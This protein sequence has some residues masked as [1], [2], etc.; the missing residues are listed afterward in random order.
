[1][2]KFPIVKTVTSA[3]LLL[4][5]ALSAAV[6]TVSKDGAADF[7]SIQAAVNRAA[8]DDEIII[9]GAAVYEEQVIIDSTKNGLFLHSE[10]V[11]ALEKPTIKWSDTVNIGPKTAAEARDE[12]KI[13]F[14][15]NGAL[16]ILGAKRVRIEGIAVDGGSV[17]PMGYNEVWEDGKGQAWPLQF[18]NGGISLWMAGD[19]IIRYCNISNAFYGINVKDRNFGGVFANSNPSDCCDSLNTIPFSDIFQTGN[20]LFEYNRIHDNSF[21]MYF[22]SLWDL[23][24]TIRYNLFYEN[25]HPSTAIAE[26]VRNLTTE[27]MYMPGGAILTKDDLLSPLAIYN[28]TFWHN[29][30][31]F[32]GSWKAGGQH[33]VFN[34]IY[35]EPNVY[36]SS[37][38]TFGSSEY[39]DMMK[40]Y[41]H[42]MHNSVIASQREAPTADF[43]NITNDFSRPNAEGDLLAK[44]CPASAEIRY[45]EMG[46]R[47]LSTT[48]TSTQFLEPD[49]SDTLV[50]KYVID[51]GWEVS[52]VKDPDGSRADL[53]AIPEAGGRFIAVT[54]IRPTAPVMVNGTVA[55]VSVSIVPRIGQIKNPKITLAGIVTKLDT[56]DVFGSAYKA[57]PAAS[58]QNV[59]VTSATPLHVGANSIEVTLPASSGDFGFFE[60]IV[61]GTDTDDLPYTSSVGFIPYRYID[62]LL[63]MTIQ[64]SEKTKVLTEVQV[65]VPVNLHIEAQ[66]INGLPEAGVLSSIALNLGSGFDLYNTAGIKIDTIINRESS[67]IDIQVVFHTVPAGSREQVLV[68]GQIGDRTFLG[69]SDAVTINPDPSPVRPQL[70]TAV[71][72]S[73]RSICCDI[74]DLSG[75]VVARS[76]GRGN[77]PAFKA[78]SVPGRLGRGIYFVRVTDALTG[79]V[80]IAK[81]AVIR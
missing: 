66:K 7:T 24:S 25:H 28:N 57:L 53:G 70:A 72:Q 33:L 32:I 58:V 64:D 17:L 43:I 5:T 76:K 75:R 26:K 47:F 81:H 21:G 9:K 23:G 71:L 78:N 31:I 77:D 10:T 12:S 34:N 39:L 30:F 29:L 6:F 56:S 59:T 80:S 48:P 61:E 54:T 68:A 18:G 20:H 15:R 52:G 42:R 4:S 73:K 44:P 38:E 51:K 22:E 74:L 45:L 13:T 63:K 67:P 3:L 69:A 14:D 19:C 11:A 8:P 1:M 41:A 60:F 62:Y 79:R 50:Q 65:G 55:S 16:I 2:N 49:W 27:G 40:T 37:D 35:A 46:R 36:L